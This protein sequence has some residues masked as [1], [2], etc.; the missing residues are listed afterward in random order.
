MP[1]TSGALDVGNI[2]SVFTNEVIKETPIDKSSILESS[3]TFE[4]FTYNEQSESMLKRTD[5][6]D[7]NTMEN[8]NSQH[9]D[10]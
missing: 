8:I 4:N 3:Q 7:R 5:S 9:F 10:F 2:D 6:L 1:T